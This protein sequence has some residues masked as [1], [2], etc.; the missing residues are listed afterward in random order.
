MQRVG[1]GARPTGTIRNGRLTATPV[2]S[3]RPGGF[4]EHWG[5]VKSPTSASGRWADT[6]DRVQCR[7]G[8]EIE[9]A[10]TGTMHVGI[11]SDVGDGEYEAEVATELGDEATEVA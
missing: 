9:A 4:L 8:G 1:A 5:A 3:P 6:P 11:E 10:L 7:E 2:E